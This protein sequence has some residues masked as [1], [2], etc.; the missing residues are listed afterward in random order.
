MQD[1]IIAF[2]GGVTASHE[3]ELEGWPRIQCVTIIVCSPLSFWWL[4]S[5]GSGGFADL[6]LLS[7]QQKP[8]GRVS[9]S[10]QTSLKFLLSVYTTILRSQHVGYRPFK[11]S[12]YMYYGKLFSPFLIG[13][14][15]VRSCLPIIFKYQPISLQCSWLSAWQAIRYFADRCITIIGREFQIHRP[16]TMPC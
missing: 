11:G 13:Y 7:L 9:Q 12:Y 1:F 4:F 16:Q 6:F 2:I 5:C 14:I 8:Y 15:N 10:G 3:R